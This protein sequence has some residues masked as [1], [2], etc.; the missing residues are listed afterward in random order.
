MTALLS[1]YDKWVMA[2]RKGQVSGVVLVDLNAAF[3]LVTPSLLIQKLKIYGF[4]EDMTNWI[5]SYLTDR[6]QS[7]WIDHVYSDFLENSIGVPQ[8]SNLGPLFFLIFFNDL[9]TFIKEDIDCYADD[10]TLGATAGQVAEIG[11]KLSSDCDQL[12]EWM[13]GNKFKLNADKTHFMIM[14]TAARL[15]IIEQLNVVMDEVVLEESVEKSE[16][17][18]GVVMQCDLKWSLQIEALTGKLKKRLAG[19]DK[20]KYVMNRFNKKNIVQGMF[21][22]VL[23]YCLPLFGG[24]NKAEVNVLQVQQNRAAQ[25]VLSFPPRTSRDLMYNKLDWLTVQQ[26]IAY[27]T[28]ITVYRIRQSREPEHLAGILASDNHNGHII[29]K[30]TQLSLYR[31]SFVFRG[32]L[33]WN[34]LPRMLRTETKLSKFKKDLRKWVVG[35]ISRFDG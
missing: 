2:A 5:L 14:G 27:Q 6:F 1:M 26:L 22:S 29:M 20:L 23:C 11:A 10:S 32:S 16:V 4:E 15:Q 13:H 12:S 8:G 17:L 24:C 35:N 28:L 18:L 34:K 30:N 7:V 33:L 19:L 3:N 25:I 31:N 21:N 9:P